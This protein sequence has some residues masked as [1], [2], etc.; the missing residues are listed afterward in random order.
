MPNNAS[1]LFSVFF[2]QTLELIVDQTNENL[3][4]LRNSVI[5]GCLGDNGCGEG[6]DDGGSD[7][8]DRCCGGF[9]ALGGCNDFNT[10]VT[11]GAPL[12]ILSVEH[13]CCCDDR[14]DDTTEPG[15][16]PP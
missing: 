14:K 13:F 4:T 1:I 10:R 8:G 11:C 2:Q 16:P 5:K 15:Q 3:D 6:G 7:G 12:G 9:K